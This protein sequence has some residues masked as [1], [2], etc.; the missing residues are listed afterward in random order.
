MPVALKELNDGKL[1]EIRLT[2]KL[3]KKDYEAFVPVVERL[4]KQHGTA[5]LLHRPRWRAAGGDGR[6]GGDDRRRVSAG[7]AGNSVA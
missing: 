1:H 4:V 7:K 5:E 6:A 2:G 3:V